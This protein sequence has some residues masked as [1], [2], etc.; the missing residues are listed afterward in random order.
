MAQRWDNDS[1]DANSD[2]IYDAGSATVNYSAIEAGTGYSGSNNV[3]SITGTVFVSP[4]A[5]TSG[6]TKS[7]GDYHIKSDA[8]EIIDSAD[9]SSTVTVDIAGGSR[10]GSINDRGADE[11][12]VP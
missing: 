3:T 4:D 12:G 5:A 11:Y 6:N 9:P 8:V 2:D 1:N 7:G 10:V